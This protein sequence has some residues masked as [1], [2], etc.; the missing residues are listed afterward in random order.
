MLARLSRGC[1]F[2]ESLEFGLYERQLN[3]HGVKVVSITQQTSDD[4]SGEM[5]RKI[6]SVFDE[7]QSKENG[8]HTL[9]AM[10]ENARQGYFNGS[11]PPFGYRVFEVDLPGR[12]GNKKK[13][14]VDLTE[15]M[16]VNKIF[17]LYTN[18]LN[19]KT[20]G[21]QQ[22]AATLN[23]QGTTRRGAH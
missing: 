20:L 11:V 10:K 6:F 23:E 9:R 21:M 4:P 7:Y 13:L 22:I 18:G 12:R 19:G 1:F 17:D 2:R 16:I 15:A 14:E 3:K 5:A 8:K